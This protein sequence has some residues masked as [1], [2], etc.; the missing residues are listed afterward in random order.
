MQEKVIIIT[1]NYAQN[2]Y[3]IDCIK[4]LLNLNYDNFQIFLV[5]NGAS[6]ENHNDLKRKIPDDKRLTYYRLNTNIGYVGGVNFALN[7]GM[8]LNPNYFLI[9][10]NDTI[11][12]KNAVNE[13][14]NC[15]K[16]NYNNAIVSGKV[17]N[18]DDPQCLQYVGSKL[19]NSGILK[20]KSLGVN[21]ID[22]G[23]YD[24]IEER[25]MLD[26]IFWLI[27]TE[28]YKVIGNYSPYF[29]FN[30]EQADYAL[31]AK[32]AGF[33][34]LYTPYAKLWHKGSVAIGGRNKNPALAYWTI[35]GTLIFRYLHLS[36]SQFILFY[37]KT[38]VSILASF[39]VSIKKFIN[40]DANSFDYVKAKFSGLM[41]F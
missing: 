4:S 13:L 33:K 7:Q 9:M 40:R 41:Y 14:V 19:I 11:I 39:I 32:K 8:K 2:Q 31:R 22:K 6:V 5:D 15:C 12:D 25:D 29:W 3:T 24:S 21:E 38:L 16:T 34:L 17:Y 36:K 37:L 1:I 35:Q 20:Y 18:Y 23:Q 30:N 28:I 27:P 26:D 10:N